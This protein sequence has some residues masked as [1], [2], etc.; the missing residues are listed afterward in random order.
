[1]V[2]WHAR[3]CIWTRWP[4]GNAVRQGMPAA[5]AAGASARLFRADGT[6]AAESRH[7]IQT[8]WETPGEA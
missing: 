1:M 5:G 3:P 2:S 4:S 7:A 6:P 8:A